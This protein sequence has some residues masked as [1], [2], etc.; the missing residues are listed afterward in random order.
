MKIPRDDA[1]VRKVFWP[2]ERITNADDRLYL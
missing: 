1:V 2:D